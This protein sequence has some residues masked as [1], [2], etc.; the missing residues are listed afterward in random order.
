MNP[1]TPIGG[2]LGLVHAGGKLSPD[3]SA[4]TVPFNRKA[5]RPPTYLGRLRNRGYWRYWDYL[6]NAI[7]E[8]SIYYRSTAFREAMFA[9]KGVF[10]DAGCGL[11]ADAL[12]ASYAGYKKCYKIDLFALDGYNSFFDKKRKKVETKHDI[13]FIRGDIC[14]PQ[15]IPDNSVD[16]ISCNA[17][18][19]LVPEEDRVLFYKEAYRM[20]KPGGQLS[21]CIVK[22]K[23]GYGTDIFIERDRCTMPGWGV[24][25]QLERNFL[26][27]FIMEK[28][29][30]TEERK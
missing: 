30:A 6:H 13:T 25:F 4:T 21:I 1:Q 5:K 27:G 7:G 24:G 2:D 12:L 19:D 17:M 10:V 28:P 23:N 29:I 14:E 22:L 20:L 3:K 15:P 8:D 9:P 16:L 11:S 18:I 26:S